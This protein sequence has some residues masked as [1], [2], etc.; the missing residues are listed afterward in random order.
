MSKRVLDFIEI[1]TDGTIRQGSSRARGD[2]VENTWG[3]SI[4]EERLEMDTGT[5][6]GRVFKYILTADEVRGMFTR[7]E[8]I[9]ILDS[10]DTVIVDYLRL[11][12]F[13]GG[14][15]D[16][17]DGSNDY[18]T[19]INQLRTLAI[20]ATDVRRDDLLLGKLIV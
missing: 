9:A 7:T 13:F 16:V 4:L 12:S 8:A 20:L 1:N 10:A 6:T 15:I 3:V 18:A 14:T 11:L 19:F 2:L 5:P 17:N